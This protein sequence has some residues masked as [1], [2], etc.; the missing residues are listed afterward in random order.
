MLTVDLVISID[1]AYPTGRTRPPIDC[2][3]LSSKR[4]YVEHALEMFRQAF[5]EDKS[6]RVTLQCCKIVEGLLAAVDER[7]RTYQSGSQP[8]GDLQD[9][10]D[11]VSAGLVARKSTLQAP[12]VQF[13]TDEKVVSADESDT[14][15]NQ[16]FDGPPDF[17]ILDFFI[18][19]NQVQEVQS[20]GDTFDFSVVEGWNNALE[21]FRF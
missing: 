17:S 6:P 18:N 19:Q 7:M 13:E 15:E 5:P 11:G 3:V 9:F 8:K 2:P 14:A 20:T 1:L 21:D 12:V 16:L 10:F 4:L